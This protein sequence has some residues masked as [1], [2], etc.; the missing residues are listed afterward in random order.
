MYLFSKASKLTPMAN[1]TNLQE[2]ADSLAVSAEMARIRGDEQWAKGEKPA[3]ASELGYRQA[4]LDTRATVLAMI[5]DVNRRIAANNQVVMGSHQSLLDGR[6]EA[7]EDVRGEQPDIPVRL[8]EAN[9]PNLHKAEPDDNGTAYSMCK[10]CG[11]EVKRVPGGQGPTWVHE[12]TGM[13]VG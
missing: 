2:L 7:Y 12:A 3:A 9:V 11:Q 1:P 8:Q 5:Q 6:I 10:H 4:L 13:V